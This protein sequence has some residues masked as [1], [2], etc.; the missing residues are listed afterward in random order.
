[1]AVQ[2]TVQETAKT[3]H[4]EEYSDFLRLYQLSS[5][6]I[7]ATNGASLDPRI[8]EIALGWSGTAHGDQQAAAYRTPGE[9]I[10]MYLPLILDFPSRSSAWEPSKPIRAL[11]YSLLQLTASH[12]IP[13]A[14]EF[15]RLQS[16]SKG[17]RIDLHAAAD[18][19]SQARALCGM[20]SSVVQRVRSFKQSNVVWGIALSIYLDIS[21]S[22][23]QGRA[24]ALGIQLLRQEAMETLDEC[25][26]EFVH[27]AAHIQGTFYSLRMLQQLLRYITQQLTSVIPDYLYELE[28]CLS[29][30]PLL[31]R[32][33]SIRGLGETLRQVRE[34]GGWGFLSHAFDLSK[35]VAS[36]IAHIEDP[37]EIPRK[38]R[39]RKA[40]AKE[41]V[42]AQPAS[43]NPYDILG[44]Q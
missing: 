21:M 3:A 11:A 39:K 25:H 8:S 4:P 29:T 19:E 35:E 16:P 26:W 17:T 27:F 12:P 43:S 34:A 36:Q 33:P 23:S 22:E 42:S 31:S 44:V 24:Q 32:F 40:S 20:I 9:G 41:A 10:V 15:R 2:N 13:T 30:L 38:K 6:S 7:E 18:V 28:K 14:V 37:I 5:V 1:M